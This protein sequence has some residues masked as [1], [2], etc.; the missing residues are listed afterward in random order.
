M[1]ATLRAG[2]YPGRSVPFFGHKTRHE[3]EWEEVR[4]TARDDLV[5]LGDDIRAL[6]GDIQMP[7][8]TQDAKQRYDP[9]RDAISPEVEVEADAAT[10]VYGESDHER[11]TEQD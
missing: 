6:D 7:G 11:S 4:E 9:A 3:R 2:R 8:V 10:A 5:A 1:R